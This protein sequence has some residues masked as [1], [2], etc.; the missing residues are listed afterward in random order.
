MQRSPLTCESHRALGGSAVPLFRDIHL[1]CSRCSTQINGLECPECDFQLRISNGIVHALPPERTTH[2][3]QFIADY[4]R[5]RAAEGR[6]SESEEYYLKVPYEDATGKNSQQWKIRSEEL[7][8]F[9][10][11]HFET[12]AELRESTG[13]WCGELLDELSPGARRISTRGCGSTHE[14]A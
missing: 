2:Y 7:R 1:Q 5:I 13:P 14:R 4:E 10:K 6:G 12:G 3:A 11:T 9:G 8:L